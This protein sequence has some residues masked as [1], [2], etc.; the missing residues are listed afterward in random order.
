MR[1]LDESLRAPVASRPALSP[2]SRDQAEPSPGAFGEAI[3]DAGR[4]RAQGQ[5]DSQSHGLQQI[6]TAKDGRPSVQ[7]TVDGFG[8]NDPAPLTN[9]ASPD[10][11]LA[12]RRANTTRDVAVKP[13]PQDPLAD[14]PRQS[15]EGED[16]AV[17]AHRAAGRGRDAV[18]TSADAS[19]E[20]SGVAATA[21]GKTGEPAGETVSDLLSMLAGAPPVAAAGPHPEGKTRPASAARDGVDSPTRTADGRSLETADGEH[22]TNGE[23]TGE[24]EP[25][26]LFRFARADGRG[27]AVSMSVSPDGERATVENGRSSVGSRAEA[28]TVLEARRY[29]GLAVNENASSVTSAIAGDSGWAEALQSGSAMPKPE[30]WSQAGKTLNTLKIQMHPVDLGMVTATLRLKDDELQV[31]LKV[32]TGE[33]FRQLRDD[34]S[35]MVKTL[36]AQGFTVDQVNIVFNGGGDNTSNGGGQSQAQAQFGQEGR[37][38]AGEEGSQGRQPRDGGRAA[39]ERVGGQ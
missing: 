16:V 13:L 6:I 37:E 10:G 15:S 25:D 23:V 36:R 11:G 3:A 24:S 8:E 7:S 33:A 26:R 39:A 21:G 17:P 27:Q 4:R 22:M 5:G 28:V 31:D 34:Q 30:A 35:E 20:A 12:P 19:D 18:R 14:T 9:I 2:G 32:E 38:R 29:L 1:P